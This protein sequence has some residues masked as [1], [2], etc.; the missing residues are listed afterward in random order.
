MENYRAIG[1]TLTLFVFCV[2]PLLW[3]GLGLALGSG[4]IQVRLPSF[5]PRA[6]KPGETLWDA[7][8]RKQAPD[9]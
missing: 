2:H 4:R 3:F 6:S 1:L 7:F 8:N 9:L 5:T